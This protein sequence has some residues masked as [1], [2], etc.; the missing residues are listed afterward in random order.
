VHNGSY[1]VTVLL[2]LDAFQIV[3]EL[4]EPIALGGELYLAL[5]HHYVVFRLS[6]DNPISV[7]VDVQCYEFLV[8]CQNLLG[9]CG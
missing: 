2:K 9:S 1:Q 3:L 6:R 4:S 5:T 8:E 7:T